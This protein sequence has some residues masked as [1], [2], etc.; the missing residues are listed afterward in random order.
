M[1]TTLLNQSTA[2]TEIVEDTL[3]HPTTSW[4]VAFS[5]GIAF[6]L[7]GFT[8]L[9]FLGDKVIPGFDM[10]L[11]W[12]DLRMYPYWVA[13]ILLLVNAL[14]LIAYSVRPALAKCCWLVLCVFGA[15]LIIAASLN[16]LSYYRLLAQREITTTFPLPFSLIVLLALFIVY[17]TMALDHRH[18]TRWPG[19]VLTMATVMACVVLFPLAQMACFGYTDYRRPADVIVVFGARAY[20]DGRCSQSLRDRVKTA[21]E[22]YQDG[23]ASHLIFSGGPGDGAIHETEAMRR[24]AIL[25]GVPDRAILRDENGLDTYSTTINTS[26]MLHHLGAKRVLAVSNFYHLPR[27]KMA[28][29][30]IGWDVYT[31]PAYEPTRY[32]M[33][34]QFLARETVALWA[35]YLSPFWRR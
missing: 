25:E 34:P 35:Y 17:L 32:T 31:V 1:L 28:Y 5:R 21:C 27:I 4:W 12:I 18:A 26:P 14:G 19:R 20:A 8:L 29:A 6:F 9:N 15:P 16:I 24:L 11:W 23:L 30:R 2:Q 7:G 10:N 33:L 3:M 13:T 22:L